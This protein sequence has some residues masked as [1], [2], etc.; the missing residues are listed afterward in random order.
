MGT[1]MQK[2]T[3]IQRH[4]L[5]P[6]NKPPG[7]RAWPQ[8][9][10]AAA[11]AMAGQGDHKKNKLCKFLSMRSLRSFAAKFCHKS[12]RVYSAAFAPWR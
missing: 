11:E 4:A 2:N 9:S 7:K 1:Q 8:E 10:A 5:F 3:Y 6:P 12:Q